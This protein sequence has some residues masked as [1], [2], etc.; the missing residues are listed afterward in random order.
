VTVYR[1]LTRCLRALLPA[2]GGAFLLA[3][4]FALATVGA[5]TIRHVVAIE[6][7]SGGTGDTVFLDAAGDVWFTLDERRRDVP[8]EHISTY[9][10]DAI[11]AVE[12]H[13]YFLHPG[14]DP[15]AVT[16]ATLNNLR[17]GRNTQG[18][19]TL[20]Q[21][22]ARTLFLSNSRTY[23]RKS[24]EAVLAGLLE[25]QLSKR[26]I[27]QLYMNRVYL[28][29]GINGVESMS[30]TLLGKSAAEL[31]LGEAALIAGIIRSPAR[32]SPWRHPDAAHQR[33]L[34][35]L[36]R[37]REEGKISS[38]EEV[39]AG[40]ET[41]SI[42][43]TPTPPTVTHGYAKAYL[44][45][46]F[47]SMFGSDNPAGWSVETTFVQELQDAAEQAVQH[48]LHRLG[49]EGLQA[50][51]VAIDPRT[52]N[53]LAMVGGSDFQLTPFNRAVHARRQPGSAFKPFVYAAA[54]EGGLSPVS[55]LGGLQHILIRAPEGFWSPRSAGGSGEDIMTIRDALVESNNAA[56]VLLQ[57]RIG[58]APVLRLASDLGVD[59]Q[60]NVPSLALGSGLVTPLDLTAAYGV[61]PAL[62]DRVRPRGLV[63]IHNAAGERVHMTH[64]EKWRVLSPEAAFQMVTVLQDVVA[65][66]TGAP[67]RTLGVVGDVGG[68][69]GTTTG[70][71]DA[72]YVGFNSAVVAG[73]WVGF[74]QPRSIGAGGSGAS[75]ALPI[76]AEFMRLTARR[77]PST[78]MLPPAGL[79]AVTVCRLTHQR[80]GD[81]CPG[82]TEYFKDGDEVPA[83]ICTLHQHPDA[84]TAEHPAGLGAP[85]Q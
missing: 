8:F 15:V 38:A 81:D 29:S 64:I 22:L 53:L 83:E 48:G 28:G 11:I 31:T 16:R 70:A 78:P 61:F 34:V 4:L 50:A 43:R 72:W 63:S 69:T 23:A 3:A 47:R 65:R 37:M 41:I 58:S 39:A 27:L 77:L 46:Q 75:A 30:Q 85:A 55:M 36:R 80:A 10:K 57:Q 40:R 32:Y 12:D 24:R 79:R 60:P 6:R 17:P 1:R 45:Q 18:G 5:W 76:W 59:N 21:Q 66:G 52:G 33:S 44:R 54:I 73:V 7:L 26:E 82:Y 19:S 71:V 14:I 74:D 49:G 68:K 51:L 9:F 67:A 2:V 35:V 62:G 42:R 25:V 56:A 20:T 84:S 13:R